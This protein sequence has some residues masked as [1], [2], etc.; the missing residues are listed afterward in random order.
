MAFEA[1][2]V[3]LVFGYP[4]GAVLPIYDA[5]KEPGSNM[6]QSGRNRRQPMPPADMPGSR[7]DRLYGHF[8]A[9][10]TNLATGIAT[11]YMDLYPSGGHY[12]Q[13]AT[14][15]VGNDAFKRWILRASPCPLPSI[16]TW[17]KRWK[18]CPGL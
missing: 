11:A 17:F 3:E 10:A 16:I 8:R 18:I 13:V 5:L 2:Q 1:E 14:S 9:G 6:S 4:G 15:M 12:R 7:D